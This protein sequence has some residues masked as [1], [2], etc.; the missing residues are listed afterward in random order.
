MFFDS[1]GTPR[2]VANSRGRTRRPGARDLPSLLRCN[3]AAFLSFLE[4]CLRWNPA[5]RFT[6]EEALQ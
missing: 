4:G 3:D 1:S 5:D 6:P 2:L